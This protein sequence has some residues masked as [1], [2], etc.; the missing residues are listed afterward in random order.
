MRVVVRILHV[1][2]AQRVGPGNTEAVDRVT[3]FIQETRVEFLVAFGTNLE[4]I[5]LCVPRYEAVKITGGPAAVHDV[6][7]VGHSQRGAARQEIAHHND[8]GLIFTSGVRRVVER[9]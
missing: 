3:R 9:E 5:G 1:R 2:T 7:T 4:I 8:P 6:Q